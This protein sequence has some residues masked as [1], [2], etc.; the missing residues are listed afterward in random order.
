MK[1]FDRYGVVKTDSSHRIISFEE[2]KFYEEGDI[3]GMAE[4]MTVVVRTP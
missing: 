4:H 1:N 2:K 3:N